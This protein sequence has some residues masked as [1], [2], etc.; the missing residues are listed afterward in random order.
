LRPVPGSDA[1]RR[2]TAG[3]GDAELGG[4]A[5]MFLELILIHEDLATAQDLRP[6]SID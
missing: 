6:A 2:I 1:P 3:A 5:Q 4:E